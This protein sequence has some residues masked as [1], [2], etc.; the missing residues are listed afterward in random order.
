MEL[1]FFTSFMLSMVAASKDPHLPYGFAQNPSKAGFPLVCAKGC[2]VLSKFKLI[3][4]LNVVWTN[5]TDSTP[6]VYWNSFK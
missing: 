4:L 5:P 2:Y 1:D 3:S 6:T